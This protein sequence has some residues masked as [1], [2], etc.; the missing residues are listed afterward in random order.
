[1]TT[2]LVTLLLASC[3]GAGLAHAEIDAPL[4]ERIAPDRVLVTWRGADPV[5]VLLVTRADALAASGVMVSDDDPDGRA[6][7]SVSPG[8]RPFVLLRDEGD[9]SV[10]RVGER[11]LPLEQGS[12]FRDLGGYR[13]ADGKRV[14]WGLI[15][16]AGAT[17]V[18]TDE[19]LA[20][21][22]KGLG[23][24]SMVDL[25]SV[26]ERQLAPTRLAAAGVE[27]VATD[28]PA[29]R[30]FKAPQSHPPGT[31]APPRRSLYRDMPTL[32][33]PQY[34]AL[35][36]RLLAAK[37]GVEVNC[38]AGQDRTGVAAALIL[39]ALGVPRLTIYQDY[40]LSTAERQTRYELPPFEA[41]DYPGNKV[42]E[43]YE[44]ARAV[45]GA[46]NPKPLFGEDGRLYLAEA[47]EEIE[48]VW[49][50]V[51]AYLEREL[52]IGPAEKAQLQALYLE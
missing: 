4:M 33:A 11:I 50:S 1:M 49:G 28:Y 23:V 43:M 35:F 30:I 51:D 20:Y 39:T 37:G 44:K 3:I 26:E 15:F 38:S 31:K 5:D 22:T 14:K 40:L 21:V 42:A 29:D 13:T 47:F 18:L 36:Q 7:V 2:R 24:T 32:L 17:P 25:R 45:P 12:N 34:K 9:G 6:L 27:V 48:T 41:K 16:R 10:V 46:L 19:D 52:G 8:T